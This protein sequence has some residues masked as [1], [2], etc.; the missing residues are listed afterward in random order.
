MDYHI[1]RRKFLL[2]CFGKLREFS[3]QH[4]VI[5]QQLAITLPGVTL[6]AKCF[7]FSV[8]FNQRLVFHG[9]LCSKACQHILDIAGLKPG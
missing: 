7:V 4:Q 1:F 3:K 2:G 8:S 9:R 5:E 6:S